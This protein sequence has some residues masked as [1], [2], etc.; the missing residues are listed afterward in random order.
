MF[1]CEFC[2]I[3][4]NIFFTQHLWVTASVFFQNLRQSSF[5]HTNLSL[6]LDNHCMKSVQIRSYFWLVFS[7]IPTEY[8]EI[9]EVTPYLDTFHADN[10]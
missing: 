8:G 3:S 10:I 2:E 1:S 6:C 5:S 9:P 4:K 7:R